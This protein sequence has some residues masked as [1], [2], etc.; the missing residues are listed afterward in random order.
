VQY[1]G[2]CGAE[3]LIPLTFTLPTR[4]ETEDAWKPR[5]GR[6][7]VKCLECGRRLKAGEMARSRN[8]DRQSATG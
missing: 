2:Y 8:A 5:P 7:V 3:R 1:C 4:E 6:A